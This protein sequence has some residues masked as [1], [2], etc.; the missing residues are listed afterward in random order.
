MEISNDLTWFSYMHV[1]GTV[2]TKRYFSWLDYQEVGDSDFC[3]AVTRLFSAV[4]SSDAAHEGSR[5]L[6]AGDFG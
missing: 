3:V 4:N 2:I 6:R 5:L 1:A